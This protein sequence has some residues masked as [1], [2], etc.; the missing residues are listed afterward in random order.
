MGTT[1]LLADRLFHNR[2]NGSFE[3]VSEGSGLSDI[4]PTL[5]VAYGDYDNAGRVDLVVGNW[6]Y[7]YAIYNNQSQSITLDSNWL[8]IQLSGAGPVNRDAI[9]S[10]VHVRRSD[11]QTLMQEVKSGSNLGSGN[12]LAVH[13]GL[14]LATIDSL[15]ISWPDGV[16]ETLNPVPINTILNWRY[17]Y[18]DFEPS[19]G[20]T[21]NTISDHTLTQLQMLAPVPIFIQ[22]H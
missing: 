20:F 18:Y 15:M 1:P 13:F 16:S 3:D 6:G 21:Q 11:G 2:G 9:G 10:R 4:R 5:G 17:P 12:D 19:P 14:G 7:D 22:P 8:T